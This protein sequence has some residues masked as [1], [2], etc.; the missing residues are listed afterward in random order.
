M[1]RTRTPLVDPD[2]WAMPGEGLVAATLPV[3]QLAP[4]RRVSVTTAEAM[5]VEPV[6]D[7]LPPDDGVVRARCQEPKLGQEPLRVGA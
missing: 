5:L 3:L 2:G 7:S 1:T 6:D 4:A